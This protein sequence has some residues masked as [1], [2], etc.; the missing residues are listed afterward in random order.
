MD[1]YTKEEEDELMAQLKLGYS[2]KKVAEKYADKWRRS[3]VGIVGKL[4]KLYADLQQAKITENSIKSVKEEKKKEFRFYS[5]EDIE[6][7]SNELWINN[8]HP[9]DIAKVYSERWNRSYDSLL[10]KIK[11]IQK[12]GRPEIKKTKKE[13]VPEPIIVV[14]EPIKIEKKEE[15][16]MP[17]GMVFEGWTK[18]VAIYPDHFRIYF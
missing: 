11:S 6:T 12:A 10:I 2:V 9:K 15:I 13:E 3:Y 8:R 16:K 4:Y 17:E 18:R 14:K 1:A 5:Y 7:L